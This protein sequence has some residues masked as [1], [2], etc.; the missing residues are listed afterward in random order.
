MKLDSFL[1]VF[2]LLSLVGA[3]A[4]LVGAGWGIYWF[5]SLFI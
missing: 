5:I 2:T 3:L 4:L 1:L